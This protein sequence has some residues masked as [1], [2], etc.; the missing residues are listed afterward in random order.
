M[1]FAAL[2]A[3]A[4]TLIGTLCCSCSSTVSQA[5]PL[6]ASPTPISAPGKLWTK[7]SDK[8]PTWYPQGTPADHPT[9]FTSGEWISTED[10]VGS[11]FFIPLH[12]LSP[13][14]RKT[15]IADALGRRNPSGMARRERA[16]RQETRDGTINSAAKATPGFIGKLPF[17]ILAFP[18]VGWKGFENQ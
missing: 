14:R 8:P 12:G 3:L 5:Q 7:V 11:R 4:A 13:E 10:A 1:N 17:R 15:L 9:D 2:P 6:P 18:F 16:I